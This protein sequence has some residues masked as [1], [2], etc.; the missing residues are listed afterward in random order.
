MTEEK[1]S[2]T[3]IRSFLKPNSEFIFYTEATAKTTI[4]AYSEFVNS[5]FEQNNQGHKKWKG[6]K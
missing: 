1:P 5:L 6:Y 2:F 4:N 3:S